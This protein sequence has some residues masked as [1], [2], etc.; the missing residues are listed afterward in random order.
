EL[1]RMIKEAGIDFK[2]LPESKP[3][4]P[5]GQYS[6]AGVIFGV[7]GGVT[8]AVIR[9]VLADASPNTLQ[10]IAECGVRG[11]EGIKAFE[12]SA[13]DLKLKIAVANGLGNADKLIAQVESGEEYFDF[14]EIMACPNGCIGGG[15]Q[16]ASD[17]ERKAERME[18]IFKADEACEYRISQDNPDLKYI[19]DHLLDGDPHHYLHILYPTHGEH[20]HH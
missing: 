1:G 11:L 13:G 16:P 4:A 9:H 8:E 19:Y 17:K 15:G 7:T 12:V 5:L 10:T 14:I 18:A 3:D 20:A 2:R 6:G